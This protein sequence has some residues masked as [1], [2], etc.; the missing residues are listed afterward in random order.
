MRKTKDRKRGVKRITPRKENSS[1]ISA[2]YPH[3]R[4]YK[5]SKHPALIVGEQAIEEYKYRKVMHNEKDGGRNN[6]MV[7]PNPN[8]KDKKPMYIG[9][10][11]RHDKKNKFEPVP[12][13]WKYPKK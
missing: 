1:H 9:K 8:K 2:P 3:F 12:L 5:K 7:Y 13:P 10:R 11:V 4:Y 6:E